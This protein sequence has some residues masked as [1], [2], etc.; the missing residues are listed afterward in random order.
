MNDCNY[1]ENN[2]IG[3]NNGNVEQDVVGDEKGKVPSQIKK[4]AEPNRPCHCRRLPKLN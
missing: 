2:L 3:N 4:Q 1:D